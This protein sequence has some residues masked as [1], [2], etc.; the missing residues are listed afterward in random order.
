MFMYNLYIVNNMLKSDCAL[1]A[2]HKIVFKTIQF[3]LTLE[4]YKFAINYIVLGQHFLTL[5]AG[6]VG[7]LC[8]IFPFILMTNDLYY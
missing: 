3:S 4:V 5:H 2:P 1:C 8:N 7:K 6:E